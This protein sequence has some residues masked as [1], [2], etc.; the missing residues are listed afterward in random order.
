M[1]DAFDMQGLR[2][3]RQA[4]EGLV[5]YSGKMPAGKLILAANESPFNLPE[6]VRDILQ[7][8]AADF[9][10]NRYPDPLA[11]DLREKIAG[12]HDVSADCVL[13]GNGGD[14]L[15]LD[16]ML[17]WGGPNGAAQRKMLQF[18]PT[19]SMYEIYAHALETEVVNLPRSTE[20]FSIDIAAATTRLQQGD[21]DLCILD[22]PNNPSG[23]LTD[24]A[25]VLTLAQASDALF[26]VD[27]AYFEFSERSM[28]EYLEQLPNL[29]IL[30]TFSKA[31]SMA[32]LR[33]GYVLAHP[34]V[35]DMLTRVRMPYSVNAFTQMAATVVMDLRTKFNYNISVITKQRDLLYAEL[36]NMDGVEV[37]PSAANYLLFRVARSAD[38]WQRLLDSHNIYIRNF[39]SA[40][41]LEDCLRVTVGND[42]QNEMFVAALRES[43]AALDNEEPN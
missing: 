42:R 35:V 23:N 1:A 6:D 17:A 40:P 18:T 41:G 37:W 13:L 2:S 9:S 22:N 21:I 29:V 33:L 38:I 7:V 14:E 43:I 5:P 3:P 15:L 12:A 31:F 39:S 11:Q 26:V 19:F 16:I 4:L 10:F 27:E 36:S 8:T 30:R 25:D 34:Q 28:L 32:G 20:D 24:L